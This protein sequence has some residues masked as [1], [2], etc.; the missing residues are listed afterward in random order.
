MKF[1]KAQ[2][3]GNDFVIVSED[4]WKPTQ[5]QVQKICDR[6]FGV[7]SDGLVHLRQGPSQNHFEWTFYNP[8]GREAEMCGNA[9]RATTWYLFTQKQLKEVFVKTQRGQ[10]VGRTLRPEYVEIETT[11][12]AVKI[13]KKTNVFGGRFKEGHLTNTGV[14]HFVIPVLKLEDILERAQELAPFIYDSEFGERGSNLTFFSTTGDLDLRAV[15]LERGVN[16]FTLSCGTGVLAAAQVYLY[17]NN[18]KGRVQVQTPGGALA[19]EMMKSGGAQLSGE[20]KLVFEGS[21]V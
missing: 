19:V 13:E 8:D 2:A 12:P 14:P 18:K 1:F 7:G 3:T 6:H 11:M 4:Q 17:L 10:F 16:D 21:I 20:A 9:A 15:T 5:Q